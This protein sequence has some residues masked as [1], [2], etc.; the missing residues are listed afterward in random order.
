[1]RRRTSSPSFS[2]A[3][4]VSLATA[5][6][7][8]VASASAR[9]GVTTPARV[10]RLVTEVSKQLR[11]GQARGLGLLVHR[12]ESDDDHQAPADTPLAAALRW[13]ERAAPVMRP[14]TFAELLAD[15]GLSPED[16]TQVLARAAEIR[17]SATDERG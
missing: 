9:R 2:R 8:P 6:E 11:S 3:L 1:V 12:V 15:R 7:G 10:E 13:A 14:D 5:S 4:S 16:E 17:A